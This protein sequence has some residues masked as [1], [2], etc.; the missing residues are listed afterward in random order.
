MKRNTI[1]IVIFII[2]TIIASI[3]AIYIKV[4]SNDNIKHLE[5]ELNILK[6]TVDNN[7]NLELKEEEEVQNL[8][9][10]FEPTK[11]VNSSKEYANIL[12]YSVADYDIKVEN[13][14]LKISLNAKDF[15]VNGLNEEIIDVCGGSVGDGAN[16]YIAVLTEK[17]NVYLSSEIYEKYNVNTTDYSLTFK[18]VENVSNIY[19]LA[20]VT[21][22]NER[23]FDNEIRKNPYWTIVA[24]DSNGNSY[25]LIYK[26]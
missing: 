21:G 26:E 10:K 15:T 23:N 3:A 20:K 6:N 24:I 25:D 13:G 5:D 4:I 16:G 1:L 12:H 14:E 17:G 9:I 11:V 8:P 7:A 19:K 2:T 22:Y 18:K